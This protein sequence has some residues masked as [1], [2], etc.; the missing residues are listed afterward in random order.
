MFLALSIVT[1]CIILMVVVWEYRRPIYFATLTAIGRNRYATVPQVLKVPFH[2]RGKNISPAA[3]AQEMRILQEDPAGYILWQ[4]PI[5]KFWMPKGTPT[6]SHLV[7]ETI[8]RHYGVGDQAV[9]KGDVVV[10]GGANIGTFVRDS[11]DRGASKVIAFEPSEQNIECLRRNFQP[12]IQDGRVVVVPKGLWNKTMV[13]RFAVFAHDQITNKIIGE[14]EPAPEGAQVFEIP[15][16][17][18]DDCRRELNLARIDYVK[19]DIEGAERHALDGAVET[20]RADA[21]RL[22]VCMYHLDD[23]IDLL[24]AKIISAN[25]S[26][27]IESGLCLSD[28]SRWRLRPH[29]LFF[30]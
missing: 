17:S 1:F 6:L 16:T 15:V 14:G 3:V 10:D 9:K 20:I 24:P 22:A 30:L 27:Q 29:I 13:V 23:D 4:T 28:G 26:Y 12:E 2:Q 25:R 5:G 8:Y 18:I 19:L 21:P 11:L 7:A